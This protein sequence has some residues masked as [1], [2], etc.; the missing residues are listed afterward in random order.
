MSRS[1]DPLPWI[2]GAFL[3]A[4][5]AVLLWW[6]TDDDR[7]EAGPAASEA[8]A[9]K[10]A[11]APARSDRAPAAGAAPATAP[12]ARSGAGAAP[13]TERGAG[14]VPANARDAVNRGQAAQGLP[15]GANCEDRP[16]PVDIVKD[17]AAQVESELRKATAYP[18][19][20]EATLGDR[21]ER[22]APKAQPFRGKWDLPQDRARFGPYLQ[23]L[24]DHLGKQTQ[25]PGLRYRVHVV[26]DPSFNAFAL[27][28]GVMAVHTAVLEGPRAVR[29]EAELVAVL[30]H[31][32]A[33]IER[34]HPVAAY[35]YARWIAGESADDAALIFHMLKMPISTEYEHEADAR[36]LELAAAAQYD[37]FAASRLW[38]RHGESADRGEGSGV[39]GIVGQVVGMAEQVLHSHPPPHQRCARMRELA[40]RLNST[41]KVERWYR[42]ERNLRERI[43]GPQQTF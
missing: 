37:P 20:D 15:T 31:E 12:A 29:S 24:V 8:P 42:G 14:W 23:G 28:G 19:A 32:M 10:V 36:G 13:A 16:N 39:G 6:A 43:P 25:R 5:A 17:A 18:D 1:F 38:V 22:E 34:R 27:P 9:A 21:L 40:I 33:H 7:A 4:G 30:G 35:Q 11:P 26:R 41:A 3:V 2:A